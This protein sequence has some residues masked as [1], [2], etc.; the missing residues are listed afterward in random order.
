MNM[1]FFKCFDNDPAS[2]G[3]YDLTL[4]VLFHFGIVKILSLVE[5]DLYVNLL[6]T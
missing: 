2:K 1:C 5:K 4:R 6:T 3:Q